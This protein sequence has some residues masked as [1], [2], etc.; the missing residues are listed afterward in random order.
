MEAI[1]IVQHAHVEGCRRGAF[2]LIA[3]HVDVVMARSPV[4]EPMNERRVTVEGED[5][6]LVGREQRVEIVIREAVWVLARWLQLHEIHDVD[7]TNLQLRRMSAK[8]VAGGE[9]P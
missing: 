1:E 9:S 6:R 3:A 7:D 5:D 4:G 2:F 8:D